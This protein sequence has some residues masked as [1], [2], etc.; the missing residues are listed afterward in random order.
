MSS[1]NAVENV[2]EASTSSSEDK[3]ELK[4][5]QSE[6]SKMNDH[7]SQL[8]GIF[9]DIK[10]L[11]L[12]MK[13]KDEKIEQLSRRVD[14][15][16][17]YSKKQNIIITGF[18]THHKSYARTVHTDEENDN[19]NAPET[20]IDTLKSRVINFLTENVTPIMP[21][22]VEACHTLPSKDP[23]KKPIVVRFVSRSSKDNIMRNL[24]KLREANKKPA[25]ANKVYVN[26]HLTRK[27]SDIAA[28]ARKLWKQKIISG[29]FVRNCTVHV[30]L[31][32]AYTEENKVYQ[33]KDMSD[34][35]KYGLPSKPE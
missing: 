23:N 11:K 10:E 19:E 8:L 26:D 29:T 13:K 34:F 28:H 3:S 18:K 30:K 17:Q 31:A 6:I 20:E 27:N 33:I 4:A 25:N 24:K 35:T 14:E 1:S 9:N 22:E 16:E 5:L 32:G 21:N 7:I 12:E 2:H 15:L